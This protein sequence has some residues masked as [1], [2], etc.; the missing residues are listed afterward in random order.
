MPL[1]AIPSSQSLAGSG[2]RQDEEQFVS[3]APAGE[4][5]TR[6]TE[7]EGGNIPERREGRVGAAEDFAMPYV[8][9]F[10]PLCV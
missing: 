3:T 8:L 1:S 7:I 5:D 6:S 4:P 2:D 10:Y 9:I